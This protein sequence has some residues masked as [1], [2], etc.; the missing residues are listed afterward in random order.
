MVSL[1]LIINGGVFYHPNGN[2]KSLSKLN[3]IVI[4]IN[5][6]QELKNSRPCANCLQFM[7]DVN[8]NKVFYSS[9]NGT[10]IICERVK[11]MIS[12]HVSFGNKMTEYIHKHNDNDKNEANKLYSHEKRINDWFNTMPKLFDNKQKKEFFELLELDLL[13]SFP[14]AVIKI[15]NNYEKNYT[16]N[17]YDKVKKFDFQINFSLK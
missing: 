17:L 4:R 11:N 12:H 9:G 16:F 14:D 6:N 3:L 7:K 2:K 10:E 13:S 5:K 15:N 8:I 1:C